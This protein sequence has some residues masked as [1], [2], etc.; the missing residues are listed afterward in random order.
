MDVIVPS[1]DKKITTAKLKGR[2]RNAAPKK[3]T[4]MSQLNSLTLNQTDWEFVL[5][6]M[7]APA[8]LNQNLKKTLSNI[9]AVSK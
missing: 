9:S 7:Q 6:L 5:D 8:Q 3:I 2:K 1:N 4:E